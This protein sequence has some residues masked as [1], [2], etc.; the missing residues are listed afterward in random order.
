MKRLVIKPQRPGGGLGFDLRDVLQA[1]GPRVSTSAW[2]I[3]N[4]SYV[5]RDERQIPAFHGSEHAKISGHEL[6][7]A[8]PN[9]LQTIDGEFGRSRLI[10]NRG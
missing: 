2:T 10:A 5:P 3:G 8:L 7:G 1:L 9:L 6:L 4:L